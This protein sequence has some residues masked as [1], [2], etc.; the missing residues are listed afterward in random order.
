MLARSEPNE[1]QLFKIKAA[2]LEI[3]KKGNKPTEDEWR[4]IVRRYCPSFGTGI[5]GGVDNSDLNA[6][7]VRAIQAAKGNI[8]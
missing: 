3:I 2:A 8:K 7:L 6:L 5:Y 4:E 1:K